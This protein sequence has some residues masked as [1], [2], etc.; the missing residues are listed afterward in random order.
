MRVGEVNLVLLLKC[1][2]N[3][4]RGGKF[5]CLNTEWILNIR[6]VYLDPYQVT[7]LIGTLLSL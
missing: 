5:R 2:M 6:E 3:S 4:M 1:W 7:E